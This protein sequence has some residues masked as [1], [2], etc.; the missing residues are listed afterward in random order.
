MNGLVVRDFSGGRSSFRQ[1]LVRTLFRI[2][3][4]TPA[5]LGLAPAAAS[6]IWS[7]NKQRFGDKVA[8]TIVVFRRHART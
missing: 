5:F 7:R 2:L 6:I 1:T 8:G 3:E 4:V